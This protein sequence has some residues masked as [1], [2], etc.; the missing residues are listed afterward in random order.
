MKFATDPISHEDAR[1]LIAAKPA[2]TRDV[3]DELPDELRGRVFTITGIEDFD[4]LQAVRDEIAKLPA[5]GDWK[6]IRKEIAA[7][8]SPYVDEAAAES[9]AELLL[10]HHGFAAY[11]ATQARIMDSMTDI[12]PYRQYLST[13][14]DKVR[15]SHAAL[16]G[17][18]LPAD[19]PFW[20]KHTPP[21]EWNCRCQVVEL[22]AEDMEEEKQ[23]DEK[24]D[25]AKQRVLGRT[26]QRML[27]DGSLVR[28]PSERVD[29][30]TPRERGGSYEWSARD[31]TLPYSEI[32]DRWDPEVRAVFEEWAATQKVGESTLLEILTP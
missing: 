14:D 20:A 17:I 27:A 13:Q 18:I 9:R 22:T 26:E 32:K 24:R 29:V 30:R 5:G 1:K 28:G 10:K 12:F 16:D 4:V 15:A 2:V 25:P 31:T 21:W 6:K 11:S 19:H 7:K 8:M 23:R 3:F